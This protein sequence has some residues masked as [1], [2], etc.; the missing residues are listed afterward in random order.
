MTFNTWVTLNKNELSQV[1]LPYL[2]L[3]LFSVRY[4]LFVIPKKEKYNMQ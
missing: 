3:K 2:F 1:L 4:N